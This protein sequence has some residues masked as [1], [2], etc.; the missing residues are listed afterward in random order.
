ML[1]LPPAVQALGLICGAAA[2]AAVFAAEIYRE[3]Q[4]RQTRWTGWTPWQLTEDLPYPPLCGKYVDAV[5]RDGRIASVLTWQ[6]REVQPVGGISANHL[7]D[8]VSSDRYGFQNPPGQWR[9]DEVEILAVGDSFAAGAHVQPGEG[10]VDLIREALGPTDNLG[11]SWNG[12]LFELASLV[13]YGPIVRPK[14]AAWFFYEGNDLSDLELERRSPL[15]MDYLQEG[16]QQGLAE[17]QAVIDALL[18]DYADARQRRVQRPGTEAAV[19][20]SYVVYGDPTEEAGI[21]WGHVLALWHLRLTWAGEYGRDRESFGLLRDVLARA[22]RVAASWG[23][24]F[25]FVYLPSHPRFR[26]A[27]ARIEA[28]AYRREVLRGVKG[29]GLPLLDLTP[30]FRRQ[31][32]PLRLFDTHYSIGGNALVAKTFVAAVESGLPAD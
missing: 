20:L 16:F 13:E 10:F 19:P 18:K 5:D 11:C 9:R 27:L 2:V 28:D 31:E 32:S 6:G 29:L 15:L 26:S 8:G 30:V 12:P 7:G 4:S 23:G 17:K 3:A 22:A 1:F 14:L 25:V 21:D 24:G